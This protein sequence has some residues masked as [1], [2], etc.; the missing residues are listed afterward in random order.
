MPRDTDTPDPTPH[1]DPDAASADPGSTRTA[2]LDAAERLFAEHGV[3]AASL[4]AITGEAGANLASVHYHFGSKE[5]LVRAV[6]RRRLEPV[7]RE[8]IA[9]LDRLEEAMETPPLED[10]LTAFVAPVLHMSQEAGE[11]G[12][13]FA[14][15]VS[16]TLAGADPHLRHL[17]LEEFEEIKRRFF[18]AFR[19]ALPEL[20]RDELLWRVHFMIG[21][22]AH[23]AGSSHLVA[24]ISGGKVDTSDVSATI[25]RLVRF[26]AAGMRSRP[27]GGPAAERGGDGAEPPRARTA[28]RA[29]GGIAPDTGPE[30]GAA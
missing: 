23:A 16:R 6:F 11:A 5:G 2:L 1:P 24:E 7:N 13:G 9:R 12:R 15:L 18:A 17:I 8:R 26:S 3:D 21:S 14:Q 10:V 27:A 28:G 20:D 22:L 30:A 29:G 19:R 25:E 4:R